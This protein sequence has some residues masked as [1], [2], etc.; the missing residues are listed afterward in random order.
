MKMKGRL[1][2][3]GRKTCQ[4]GNKQIKCRIKISNGKSCQS[5]M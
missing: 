3:K 1:E 5:S 4:R 2:A